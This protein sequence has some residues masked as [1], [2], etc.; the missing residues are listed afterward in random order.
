MYFIDKAEAVDF[1][2]KIK[3]GAAVPANNEMPKGKFHLI[4]KTD[5]SIQTGVSVTS[6]APCEIEFT[7]P[8]NDRDTFNPGAPYFRTYDFFV[9]QGGSDLHIYY[10]REHPR[11]NTPMDG[12][13]Y[14]LPVK[15]WT[16]PA[17]A[18]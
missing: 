1:F 12:R 13:V 3:E 7:M 17:Q 6:Q 8:F 2:T 5:Y 18:F 10:K 4:R 11:V 16:D 9:N 14:S 15:I